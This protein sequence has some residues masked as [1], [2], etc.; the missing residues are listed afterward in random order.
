M[1]ADYLLWFRDTDVLSLPVAFRYDVALLY[2]EQAEYDLEAAIQAYREDERWEK[3]HPMAGSSRSKA[4][5]AKTT[6][7]RRF[8]GGSVSVG[9]SR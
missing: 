9:T 7:M 8:V 2:L 1:L 5:S 6:G 4:S 3:E